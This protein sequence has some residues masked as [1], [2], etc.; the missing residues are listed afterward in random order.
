[1][2][3]DT[4]LF[5]LDGTL[6]DPFQ[7]G[8]ALEFGCRVVARCYDL[9]PPWRIVRA[10]RAAHRALKTHQSEATNFEVMI[11]TFCRESGADPAVV[12]ERVRIFFESDFPAM[13][14]RFRPVPGAAE[15][16]KL[17]AGLG[18]TLV[19]ATNPTVPLPTIH[20]R[21]AWA[22][23]EG[24][25]WAFV[26]HPENMTRSKPDVAYYTELL[27]HLGRGPDRCL[28][29]GNDFRKDLAA[30]DA[31][32]E[33]FLLERPMSAKA[34]AARRLYHPDHAGGY[35]E[36]QALIHALDRARRA[37]A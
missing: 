2:A 13:A 24:I 9:A 28:M 3:I 4:L 33:A 27:A 16:V 10:G 5:D 31:G 15:T 34:R 17:A 36:L 18:F 37:L 14:W 29:I 30:M 12:R 6:V 32:I 11:A 26:T 35:A 1:M 21:L 8:S 22:G 25:D 20:Q 7:P 23:L 19:L